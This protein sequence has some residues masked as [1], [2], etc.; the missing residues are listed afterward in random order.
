MKLSEKKQEEL[1]KQ[2]LISIGEDINKEGLKDTPKRVVKMWKEIY[3]GYD[4]KQEPKVTVFNNGAEGI[5]YDEMV[6]DE[7]TFHSQC[8]HHMV[9]FS[10]HYYFA[11]IYSPKGKILGLSKVA[12]VVDYFSAK[13]QIQET[14]TH[15]IVNYLW[16]K[17]SENNEPPLGMGLVMEAEHLCKTMRGVRKKGL[18][19]TTKL[20]G[21][22]KTDAST[23]AEFMGWVNQN[24]NK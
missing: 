16:K 20:L 11:V 22:M 24:G 9:T 17:L 6:S 8:S 18:M 19:R 23:R 5:I 13:L 3:R 1:V 15:E 21:V 12:R 4:K 14:L 10:G 2:I 7:G